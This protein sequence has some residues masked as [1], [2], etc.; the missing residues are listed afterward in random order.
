[1][2]LSQPQHPE[3]QRRT[4]N[5]YPANYRICT[6][7]KGPTFKSLSF[8]A[9]HGMEGVPVTTN[10]RAL[11]RL[12][13]LKASGAGGDQSGPTGRKLYANANANAPCWLDMEIHGSDVAHRV[14]GNTERDQSGYYNAVAATCQSHVSHALN[15][16]PI[17]L[18][19]KRDHHVE[20]MKKEQFRQ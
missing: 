5:E 19:C 2:G 3:T 15:R 7:L 13:L 10:K 4:G 1:M 8:S 20:Q 9:C 11:G 17:N 16:D 14:V 6:V 12:D 18:C